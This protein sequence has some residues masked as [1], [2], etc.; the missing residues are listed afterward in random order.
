MAGRPSSCQR[1]LTS[2]L[3]SNF[4]Y[5]PNQRI[6]RG[7][8]ESPK[9]RSLS[10]A[11][12]A[13]QGRVGSQSA[14]MGEPSRATAESPPREQCEIEKSGDRAPLRREKGFPETSLSISIS[15]RPKRKAEDFKNQFC[16]TLLAAMR[17]ASQSKR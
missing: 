1:F 3:N 13:V 15:D 12:F 4:P 17:P 5:S 9:P 7:S 10:A 11:S 2:P 8:Q 6:F 14:P 16:K